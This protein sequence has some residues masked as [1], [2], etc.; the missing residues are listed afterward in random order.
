MQYFLHALNIGP[1]KV[2]DLALNAT[3]VGAP[4]ELT[5]FDP[6]LPYSP[7]MR[8]EQWRFSPFKDLPLQGQ[9][10]GVIRGAHA[11]IAQV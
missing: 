4:A 10:L 5:L 6:S 3:E 11:S 1:R 2:L 7:N 9:I 8:P